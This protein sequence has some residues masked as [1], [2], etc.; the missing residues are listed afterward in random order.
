MS[1]TELELMFVG[2]L[3]LDDPDHDAYFS[4]S[5]E[6]LR[7]ADIAVGQ[8]EWPHTPRGMVCVVDIPAP[9]VPVAHLDALQASGIEVATLAGNHMFDQ[10]PWG[11]IDTLDGLSERGIAAVGAGRDIAQARAPAIIERGGLRVGFL[12]YNAVGPRESWATTA[13]AG[14]APIHV[15]NHF[16]LEIASPGSAPTEFSFADPESLAELVADV[17]ALK[18]EVDLVC[19]ALHKGMGFVRASL[20]QYERPLVQATIDAGADVVVGHHAHILRGVEIYRDRPVFHGVNHFIAAYTERS[21]PRSPS[22]NRP[23]PRRSPAIDGHVM[24]TELANFPFPSESRH[25]MVACVRVDRAGVLEAGLVPCY[26]DRLGHP[27]PVSLETDAA[28]TVDY[29]RA[30]TAEAGLEA[31]L[32]WKDGRVV[33]YERGC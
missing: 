28:G 31:D 18:A 33:F 7:S 8:V 23:R 5:R 27:V 1:E 30:I 20:A 9:A 19:V 22:A 12:S 15:R 4:P 24:D 32:R 14:V 17:R 13:K 11:V 21:N 29:I 10:G 3:M 6:L 16:E 2:D 25:T 26:I